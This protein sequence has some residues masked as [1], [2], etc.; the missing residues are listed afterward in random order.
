MEGIE[1][2]RLSPDEGA[3]EVTDHLRRA[4]AVITQIDDQ[5]ICTGEQL[6]RR[7][8]SLTLGLPG[9]AEFERRETAQVEIAYIA[10]HYFRATHPIVAATLLGL[11]LR[12]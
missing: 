11:R 1:D 6:Q 7:F 12:R 5:R 2:V 3:A 10:W 8:D 9:D 4:S